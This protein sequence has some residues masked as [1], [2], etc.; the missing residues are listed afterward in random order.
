MAGRGDRVAKFVDEIESER[1]AQRSAEPSDAVA[2][3]KSGKT[4]PRGEVVQLTEYDPEGQEKVIAGMLYNAPNNQTSWEET[5]AAVKEMDDSKKRDIIASYLA[6]RSQRWQKVGRAFEN[7]YVRFDITMNIGSWRA[8]HR[9]RMLTQQRQ[10]FTTAHGYDTPPE[11]EASG[12]ADS[13]RAALEQAEAIHNKIAEH[14]PYIAQYAVALAHRVRFQQFKNLR[15][16]FW[17]MELRTI[18]EGHPDYR[19][20]EQEKFKLLEKVYPLITEHMHVNTGNYD[21]ARRGQEEKIQEK[22]KSL[23][24][25]KA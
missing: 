13:Y 2:R 25:I 24:R 14:N 10:L 4:G 12:L 5:L 3:G 18:P 15:E 20:I 1:V 6:G 7:A 8:L 22:L 17:E 16:C 9:H 21:F 19:R 11:L 23:E